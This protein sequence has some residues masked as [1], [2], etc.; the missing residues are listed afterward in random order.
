MKGDKAADHVRS[1]PV[2]SAKKRDRLIELIPVR[3][4]LQPGLWRSFPCQH[5]VQVGGD[6]VPVVGGCRILSRR[7]HKP[8]DRGDGQLVPVHHLVEPVIDACK[9]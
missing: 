8:L 6:P 3:I 7:R 1:N 4:M 2:E 5:P 9:I